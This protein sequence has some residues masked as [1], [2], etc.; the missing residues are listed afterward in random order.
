MGCRYGAGERLM[1][2]QRPARPE[3]LDEATYQ[4]LPRVLTVRELLVHIDRP[5]YRT[6]RLIVAT[7]LLDRQRVQ[8]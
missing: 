3:W 2:W 6:R 1:F 5:G 4:S 7:T 8:P